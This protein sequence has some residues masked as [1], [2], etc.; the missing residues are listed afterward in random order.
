[1]KITAGGGG[2]IPNSPV[3]A[4]A[5]NRKQKEAIMVD[6]LTILTIDDPRWS[7]FTRLLFY[8]V[9]DGCTG[10]FAASIKI[11]EAMGDVD[12]TATLEYFE[13]HDAVCDCTVLCSMSATPR[14][15]A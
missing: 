4:A 3:R 9:A 7:E 11:L 12:I 2:M 14:S 1:M 13:K 8:E 6:V 15:A 5:T 10:C